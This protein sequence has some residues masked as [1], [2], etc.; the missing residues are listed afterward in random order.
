M[1]ANFPANPQLNETYT[2]ANITWRWTGSY[3]KIFYAP[4]GATG[5][6]GVQGSPGGATGATGIQGPIGATG[7]TGIAGNIG[8]IGATGSTGPAGATGV[9]S[10]LLAVSTSIIPNASNVYDIGTS[11]LSWRDAYFGNVLNLGSAQISANG[12][13]IVLPQGS[14]IG[15]NVIGVGS[16]SATITVSDTAPST[17]AVGAL[18]FNTNTGR[19][20]IYYNDGDDFY[21]VQPSGAV[22]PSGATGATGSSANLLE[23]SSNILPSANITYDLGST[24][25]RWRDL[26]LSGN[27]INLGGALITSSNNAVILPTGSR[28]GNVTIGSGGASV[29][30][31]N[32]A[33][34]TGTEGSLWLDNETGKLRIYYGGAWAGVAVGPVGATGLTGATGA[35]GLLGNVG[36]T[37]ATG[38]AGTQGATGLTGA[39]GPAG[40]GGGG[41]ASV[42][43]SGTRP[44]GSGE[45][46]LWLN[47]ETGD[48][49]VYF[50]NAWA[51]V[52]GGGGSVNIAAVSGQPNPA[53]DFISIPAGTTAQRPVSPQSGYVRYNTTTLQV[54]Y[55]NGTY[56][57]WMSLLQ[58]VS[59]TH[60]TL[61]T[62]RE[63]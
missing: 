10:N 46:N 43:V 13:V 21:W 12:S 30:V 48:L 39:T 2:H 5:A 52:S 32:T 15:S 54:E 7:A 4:A 29:T 44:A 22:G 61:P 63:V 19:L 20:L 53:T 8:G 11:A 51:V 3:W 57:S 6:T 49:N 34:V 16:G 1:P 36:L 60:L 45:G 14:R 28:I 17:P 31:S 26:Y 18:W 25:Q 56:A 58:P 9:S 55:Y 27:S 40:S 42:T 24:S 59:Y 33:P 37:G 50:G 38:A 23:V 41:G 47:S 62:N 35:Q